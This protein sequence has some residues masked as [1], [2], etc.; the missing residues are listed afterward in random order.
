MARLVISEA[1]YARLFHHL[2]P[3][4]GKE[5]AAILVCGVTGAA[6]DRL[7]VGS[8]IEVPYDDCS[9]RTA[10]RVTWPGDYLDR[11]VTA[12][13]AIDGGVILIHSHPGGYFDFSSIDDASD[14]LT[15]PC[16]QAG[17]RNPAAPIGSA[18]MV[19]DGRIKARLF[20][21]TM[22]PTDI[23]Q[24]TAV[25]HDIRDLGKQLDERPLAFSAAMTADLATKTACVIGISGTGSI[26]AELLGRLGVGRLVLIDFDRV[27]EKNLNRILYAT[28]KDIG[29]FKTHV[30][31]DA[32]KAH[33]P[34]VDIETFETPVSD[35]S[36]LI[37][38]S[39]SDILFSCVDSM[40][41]RYHCDLAVQTFI[42]PM[43]D[44]GVVIPTRTLKDK[45]SVADVC[46]RIDY[47]FPSG[48]TLWDRGEITGAGL[49]A[50]YIRHNDPDA[51][52]RQGA[53]GY[54]KG[55]PDEAPSVISLNMR[56]ASAGVNEWLARLYGFRHDAN[57]NYARCHFSL[58]SGEEEF[59]SDET[60]AGRARVATFGQGLKRPLLGLLSSADDE[61]HAA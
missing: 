18:V 8:V 42:C 45:V 20:T 13:D 31:R 9:V 59:E 14:A 15:I 51:Y 56:A 27:E 12:M 24:L 21:Q 16:L 55:V 3:G 46:G 4:D 41:G 43:I 49:T 40:E 44:I 32:I 17:A 37:A 50:E 33:H 36:A 22:T 1:D 5:A 58:A 47:V 60:D 28:P 54:L 35:A 48:S 25:G 19:P 23:R 34:G 26:V 30:L 7:C 10:T 2:F 57:E 38:L 39:G 61:R 53:E 11:A 6:R 52:A 29:R